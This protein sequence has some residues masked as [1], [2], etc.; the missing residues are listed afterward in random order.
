MINEAVLCLLQLA[1]QMYEIGIALNRK[2]KYGCLP[3]HY[4]CFRQNNSF[5]KFLIGKHFLLLSLS[6]ILFFSLRSY[7]DT[8]EC[9]ICVPFSD[10]PFVKL[11]TFKLLWLSRVCVMNCTFGFQ[12]Y[13]CMY[14]LIWKMMLVVPRFQMTVKCW[15]MLEHNLWNDN[16]VSTHLMRESCSCFC[17]LTW[18]LDTSASGG[19]MVTATRGAGVNFIAGL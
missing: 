9:K 12:R 10:R 7:E 11:S 5:M 6:Q 15:L 8:A 3:L 4:A 1:E 14:I 16:D 18:S 17:F 13:G 2:D 19:R